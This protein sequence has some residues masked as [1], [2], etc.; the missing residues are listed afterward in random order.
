MHSIRGVAVR[1]LVALLPALYAIYGL[2]QWISSYRPVPLLTKETASYLDGPP[3][4]LTWREPFAYDVAIYASHHHSFYDDQSHFFSDAQHVATLRD[5]KLQQGSHNHNRLLLHTRAR[6]RTAVPTNSSS[7][8]LHLFMQEASKMNPHPSMEDKLIVQAH[9]RLLIPSHSTSGSSAAVVVVGRSRVAWEAMLDNHLFANRQMAVDVR[10]MSV[11][12]Y[13]SP[14]ERRAYSPIA[15]DNPLVALGDARRQSRRRFRDSKNKANYIDSSGSG[16]NGNNSK[17]FIEVTV[18]LRRVSLEWMRIVG[19]FVRSPLDPFASANATAFVADD[20]SDMVDS[21]A[22]VQPMDRQKRHLVA[23]F[24]RLAGYSTHAM[25]VLGGCW[26]LGIAGQALALAA[27]AEAGGFLLAS[28]G[29][30]IWS[31][32]KQLRQ[33]RAIAIAVGV[34]LLHWCAA[35][36][37]STRIIALFTHSHQ[38]PA[39]LLS[40]SYYNYYASI[41]S[42]SSNFSASSALWL[43]QIISLALPAIATTTITSN[44]DLGIFCYDRI[45]ARQISLL[46]AWTADTVLG[47][48]LLP[49]TDDYDN[50]G[51]AAALAPVALLAITTVYLTYKRKHLETTTTAKTTTTRTKKAV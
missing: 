29:M 46:V 28:A 23:I 32:H 31:R 38:P 5:I 4:Q 41:A 42:S 34:G 12:Q 20:N 8:Y 2:R 39:M 37:E 24:E 3:H 30:G 13:Y 47:L 21:A 49:D 9:T 51:R 10:R 36:L 48:T 14:S 25:F 18:T 6:I 15:W 45:L 35:A 22:Y 1:V 43:L 27:D 16:G 50:N 44:K 26:A 17:Q 40:G 7:M 19:Q 11:M 33:R